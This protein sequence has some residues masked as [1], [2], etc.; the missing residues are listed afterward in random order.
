MKKCL[1]GVLGMLT[2]VLGADEVADTNWGTRAGSSADL[3]G[4]PS[5]RTRETVNYKK[6]KTTK[7]QTYQESDAGDLYYT[8]PQ[9]RSTMYKEYRGAGSASAT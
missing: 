6:Y 4:T 3:Y 8:K 9:S 7:T 5:T 1:T 2:L